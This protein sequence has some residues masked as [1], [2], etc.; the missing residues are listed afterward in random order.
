MNM[1]DREK[2]ISKLARM[3]VFSKSMKIMFRH[4]Q[5]LSKSFICFKKNVKEDC[6]ENILLCSF[7]EVKI[8]KIKIIFI[9]YNSEYN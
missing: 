3:N 1:C 9:R 7:V 5:S 2:V 4:F 6:D 8:K